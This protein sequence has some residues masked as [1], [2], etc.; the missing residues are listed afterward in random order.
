MKDKQH[1]KETMTTL[2]SFKPEELVVREKDLREELFW[3]RFKA[4][5][6]Q[7][8]KTSEIRKTRKTI[9]RI[10]TIEKQTKERGRAS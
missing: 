9:A 3:L 5:G 10:R 1:H 2:R 8:E 6:G 7:L 4:R